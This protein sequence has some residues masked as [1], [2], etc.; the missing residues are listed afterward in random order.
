MVNT[1]VHLL[2][3]RCSNVCACVLE[4]WDY[5]DGLATSLWWITH[6]N[7]HDDPMP[8]VIKLL[9]WC[10]LWIITHLDNLP[11][12]A[13][14]LFE[15]SIPAQWARDAIR[16]SLLRQNDAAPSFW[17]NNDAIIASFVRREAAICGWGSH[18][19]DSTTIVKGTWIHYLWRIL[20][21]G[22]RASVGS[23]IALIIGHQIIVVAIWS[24]IT[25]H[26]IMCVWLMTHSRELYLYQ[27]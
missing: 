3:V 19:Q 1:F 16:T 4:C 11:L 21:P 22:I 5:Y 8:T 10:F 13:N 26:H 6:W 23:N 27:L 15:S 17:R 24:N 7:F 12:N 20:F 14:N 18:F 25:P 9:R 2:P